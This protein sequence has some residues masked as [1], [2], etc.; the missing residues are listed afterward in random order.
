[1]QRSM[2]YLVLF[3]I[4]GLLA[5]CGGKTSSLPPAAQNPPSALQTNGARGGVA[6]TQSA[7]PNSNRVGFEGRIVKLLPRGF[8]ML[9]PKGVGFLHINTSPSTE[10]ETDGGSA[11]VGNYAL[12]VGTGSQFTAINALYIA[13]FSSSP[14]PTTLQGTY[15]GATGYGFWL[16]TAYH[17]I[18]PVMTDTESS[19]SG[20]LTVGAVMTVQGTGSPDASILAASAAVT[21]V[22]T[23]GPTFP[24]TNSQTHVI[25]ADYLGAPDGS[26]SVSPAQ[27]AP[28]L[29]W[30]E[31]GIGNTSA[32]A[33]AG[34][35]TLVYV[36]MDRLSDTDPPYSQLSGDEFEQ[37]C[38]GVRIRDYYDNTTQY[39]TNPASSGARATIDAYV[40][41]FAAGYPVDA[42]F[43]DDAVPLGGY[44]TS[45]FWPAP[46]CDYSDSSWVDGEDDM[47]AGYNY[48]TFVNGLSQ[49]TESVPLPGTAELLANSTTIGANMESCYVKDTSPTEEDRWVWAET[50]NTSL[51]VTGENKF[52]MC[53]AMDYAS[54]NT[55]IASRIYT[56]ASFLMTYNP[57]YSIFREGYATPSGLHVMPESQFVPT[58]P[59]VPQPGNV[60]ALDASYVYVREYHACYYAG[61]LV[62]QC[63]MVVNNDDAAHSTPALALTYNHT[64]ALS[65]SGILDGGSVGFDGP[66]PPTNL[67][68]RSAFI[69]L[70]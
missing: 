47:L 30:A 10:M 44:P 38:S 19:L 28:Y 7:F 46:P 53:F 33:A 62:G 61:K 35:K 55:E 68:P 12:L 18:V 63:A 64:L 8:T 25:T 4:A 54:A 51:A 17:G 20:T 15:L 2:R 34:I 16:K 24:P 11:T 49:M 32:I 58:A 36:D 50:E 45:Y 52:F 37:T 22:A 66:A 14:R 42:I 6:T 41:A 27:A 5:A 56:L 48:N 60:S 29:N 9:G 13:T 67:A 39:V 57:T 21:P 70:P 23:P 3:A 40:N 1:M 31:T 43:E 65:G 69:A 26:T 59:V